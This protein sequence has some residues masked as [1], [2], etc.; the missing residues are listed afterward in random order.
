MVSLLLGQEIFVSSK[1]ISLVNVV[2]VSLYSV[3][4]FIST[5]SGQEGIEPATSGFGD[6]RSA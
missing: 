1:F 2:T 3:K 6:Q 5:F 4:F